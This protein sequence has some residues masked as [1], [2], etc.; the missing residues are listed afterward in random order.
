M[1]CGEEDL[2]DY[3]TLHG[4]ALTG[5]VYRMKEKVIRQKLHLNRN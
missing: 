3:L 5:S 4:F 2:F 1:D